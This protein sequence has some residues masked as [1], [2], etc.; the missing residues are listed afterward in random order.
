MKSR[1]VVRFR[2]YE[3]DQGMKKLTKMLGAMAAGLCAALGSSGCHQD[4]APSPFCSKWTMSKVGT[5]DSSLVSESSGMAAS[6]EFS[7]RLY[8]INDSGDGPHFYVSKLNGTG[9]RKVAW[10]TQDSTPLPQDT[11]DLA[12]GPCPSGAVSKN[13]LFI[14]DIGDNLKNRNEI[15]V[16]VVGETAEFSESVPALRLL[17]L[18]YPDGPHDA[19]AMV[20]TDK[21]DLYLFTKEVTAQKQAGPSQI[22]R[23]EAERWMSSANDLHELTRVGEINVPA[24]L[25]S[26][27]VLGYLGRIVTGA[28]LHPDGSRVVLLTYEF[29]ID[30]KMDAV[31]KSGDTGLKLVP[32]VD[33]GV[34]PIVVLRQQE[35][36]SWLPD[37]SGFI[38]STE[39]S[40][41]PPELMRAVCEKSVENSAAI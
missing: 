41:P 31:L 35:S 32:G 26:D 33:Y 1:A 24:L 9:L 25:P 36:V 12:V 29:A 39:S 30:L 38:Y 40:N 22:F 20:V 17:S 4:L 15:R 28:S 19:E 27:G 2:I 23:L 37:G 13:C 10:T 11:E 3:Y 21:G 34:A 8:H 7:D 6:Q 14:G 5:L 18:K 16:V